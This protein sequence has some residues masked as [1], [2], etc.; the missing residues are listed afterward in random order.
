MRRGTRLRGEDEEGNTTM[1]T[2]PLIED[3]NGDGIPDGAEVTFARKRVNPDTGES[4]NM[5]ATWTKGQK[6]DRYP[7]M[8]VAPAGAAQQMPQEAPR[9]QFPD[10]YRQFEADV[11]GTA[12][13][14]GIRRSGAS[15]RMDPIRTEDTRAFLKSR[16]NDLSLAPERRS[17]ARSELAGMDARDAQ[18]SGQASLE[19]RTAMEGTATIEAGRAAARAKRD[20]AE[21]GAI[22]KVSA[23][24]AGA[25]GRIRAEEIKAQQE[26]ANRL[27][28]ES[29]ARERNAAYLEAR[30]V[31]AEA[32]KTTDPMKLRTMLSTLENRGFG[33][34]PD[35]KKLTIADYI[36]E[37]YDPKTG[38]FVATRKGADGS[39]VA[40]EL[41]PVKESHID[42]IN[43]LRAK[44]GMAP[45]FK[46]ADA[47]EQ[48]TDNGQRTTDGR[49]QT[50]DSRP[51]HGAP[52]A[53][54]KNADGTT[55]YRDA[56]GVTWT[57]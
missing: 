40:N 25:Q 16:M 4:E 19:R 2:R 42:A 33:Q 15:Q 26:E 38:E 29:M 44:L 30:R 17:A 50:T 28:R 21:V 39:E 36:R 14:F 10:R 51:Q 20:V 23:A 54:K 24:E 49:P 46:R 55:S 52:V 12:D 6:T 7:M 56:N 32:R 47:G 35:G 8:D 45:L 57:E 18:A 11:A 31:S 41:D 9:A 22:G 43:E 5:T 48:T 3:A 34:A 13:A 37:N 27:S 53:R 1:N